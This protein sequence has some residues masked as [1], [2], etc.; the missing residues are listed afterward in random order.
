MLQ[1][2]VSHGMDVTFELGNSQKLMA[3][4]LASAELTTFSCWEA[5]P[6]SWPTEIRVNLRDKV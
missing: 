6:C 1:A 2:P 5:A 3:V 4:T